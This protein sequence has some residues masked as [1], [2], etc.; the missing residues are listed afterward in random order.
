MKNKNNVA[1]IETWRPGIVEIGLLALPLLALVP[2]VFIAPALSMVGLATQ[3]LAVAAYGILVSLAAI[4][5]SWRRRDGGI[6]IERRD[7]YLIGALLLF[8]GWQLTSLL[9]TPTKNDGFR[10]VA[11]W[12]I[13]GTFLVLQLLRLSPKLARVIFHLLTLICLVL[14]VTILYERYIFGPV[15]LGFFFNHGITAEI[16]VTLVP[17]QVA[18]FFKARQKA[19]MALYFVVS[20]VG[21]VAILIGLRRGAL[22]AL[23]ISLLL[24]GAFW[25]FKLVDLGNPRRGLLVVIILVI[26]AGAVGA[27]NWEEIAF[28]LDGAIRVASPEGGLMI[29]LRGWMTAFEM[30]KK[31]PVLGVGQAGYPVLYGDYRREWVNKP[32]NATLRD[33]MGP[34]D[35]DEIR[36]PLAH[37]E[38]L[39][40]LV[41]LGAVGLILFLGILGLLGYRLWK[42]IRRTRSHLAAGGLFGLIAFCI[43]SFTSGFSFRYTPE[44]IILAALLGV[45]L[46]LSE[47]EE[48]PPESDMVAIPEW[49]PRFAALAILI[50]FG[51]MTWRAERVY[52]SQQLQG[53]ETM[54]TEVLDFAYYPDSAN[55]NE[56]LA[57][58]YRQ[59]LA[60]DPSNCGA[61]LGYALLLFQ[62]KRNE[63]ALTHA[64]YAWR[65][66]FSRP[67][68]YVLVAFIREQLGDL[69]RAT[70][71]LEE[72]AA[73][74]PQSFFVRASLAE[75]L[76]RGGR[77][78]EMRRHQEEMYARDRRSMENWEVYLRS[79][80][81]KAA[82]EASQRGLL[83][84]KDFNNHLAITLVAIRGYHYLAK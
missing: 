46:V 42:Q 47:T 18:S 49:L 60:Y 55:G 8:T 22:L 11:I 76:R 58:R 34:E 59:V 56:S 57:R 7:L 9:Y 53:Q 33:L 1:R 30:V 16:L 43:S 77:V 4:W 44:T 27:R 67:F 35:E 82:S 14:A 80:L 5:E 19:L 12:V 37:N 69:P 63:E 40:T 13:F 32:E 24:L 39:Q 25:L 72:A 62:L 52:R 15:M 79:N 26:G 78:E 6:R 54:S 84:I 74:Y 38:Y 29:R 36:S 41:E 51:A 2:N 64:E 45:V 17:V 50:I 81:E 23:T 71:I 68:A 73:A 48:Q 20:S 3:E 61:H 70:A 65:N 28:R 66:G 21:I 83:A 31:N 10:L 75:L